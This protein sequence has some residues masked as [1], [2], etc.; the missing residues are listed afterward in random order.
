MFTSNELKSEFEKQAKMMSVSAGT[1][2]MQPG[3]Y[4]KMIPI[5]IR[6]CIR[7]LRQNKE[8]EETFL[9]HLMPGETCALTLTC[10]ASRKPGQIKAVA[11]D[12][13]E[14]W[15]V[16]VQFVDE[17]QQYREWKEFIAQTYQSRFDKMLSVIDDIAFKNMD[18]RLWRYL[19]ARAKAKNNFILPVNHEEIAQELNIQ[20]EAATRLLKKLKDLG[21]IETGRNQIRILKKDALV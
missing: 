1:I 18:E 16:P 11:E 7:V 21:Y 13:T 19:I 14:L 8:G 12:N 3:Q 2:L 9:Y 10:C 4:V 5:I 15:S 6:G 20:R 17:W